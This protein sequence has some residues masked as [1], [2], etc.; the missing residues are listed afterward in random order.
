MEHP[1]PAPK[2]QAKVALRAADTVGQLR[3]GA[4][5]GPSP[6][7]ARAQARADIDRCVV[8]RERI[9]GRVVVGAAHCRNDQCGLTTCTSTVEEPPQLISALVVEYARVECCGAVAALVS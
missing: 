3:L 4:R 7:D 5:W 6:C 1:A 2:A 9:A 8:S